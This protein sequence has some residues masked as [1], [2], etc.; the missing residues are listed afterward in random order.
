MQHAPSPVGTC[1][2]TRLPTAKVTGVTLPLAKAFAQ[3]IQAR[4][5]LGILC[6]NI[7]DRL[8]PWS[9]VGLGNLSAMSS[10]FLSRGS[11]IGNWYKSSWQS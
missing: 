6:G 10:T 4:T 8:K 1:T 7:D 2:T 3:V 11:E 5:D 9:P